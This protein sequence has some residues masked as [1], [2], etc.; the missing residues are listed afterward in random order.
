M[1]MTFNIMPRIRRAHILINPN[2]GSVSM[3]ERVTATLESEGRYR[4]ETVTVEGDFTGTF[5]FTNLPDEVKVYRAQ[6][7]EE[8]TKSQRLSAGDQIYFRY[9][10]A[11]DG[12]EIQLEYRYDTQEVFYLKTEDTRYQDMVGTEVK[13]HIWTDPAVRARGVQ[14]HLCSHKEMGR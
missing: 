5:W 11:G 10:G 12:Q 7:G 8:V 9:I 14:N 13:R 1:S 6:T 3:K 4:T 2:T